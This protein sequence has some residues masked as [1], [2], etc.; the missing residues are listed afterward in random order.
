[1]NRL[2]C[3]IAICPALCVAQQS[4]YRS[5]PQDKTGGYSYNSVYT[6]LYHPDSVITF[7]GSVTGV[8]ISPPT[9][10][11]E[12]AVT[13]LVKSSNGGTSIVELGPEW[14]IN[15]QGVQF[16]IKDFVEITGSKTIEN[17][18]GVI[19]AARIAVNSKVL[20]LRDNRGMPI[21]DA[22]RPGNQ[23]LGP[24]TRAYGGRIAAI[25]NGSTENEP[26]YITVNTD[27][28]NVILQGLPTWYM[29]HQNFTYQVGQSVTFYAGPNLQLTPG[30]TIVTDAIR[31]GDN[32]IIM[33]SQAGEPVWRSWTPISGG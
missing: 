17:G 3:F 30:V 27:N 12:P 24:A 6:K 15:R 18:R 23:V 10:N 5:T 1:M 32:I 8:S 22:M 29:A 33:R 26:A 11:M 9:A 16:N 25:T 13:I 21:W 7:N 28:G 20:T 4:G 14:Y 19:L 2:A 31:M